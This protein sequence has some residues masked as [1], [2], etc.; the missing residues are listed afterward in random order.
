MVSAL[1]SKY[2]SMLMLTALCGACASNDTAS[3]DAKKASSTPEH[4]LDQT[5][6]A[7]PD[8]IPEK[9]DHFI[10][11]GRAGV[12]ESVVDAVVEDAWRQLDLDTGE[13]SDDEEAWDLSFSRYRVRING[14]ISGPGAVSVATLDDDF[15]D[16]KDIPDEA[17]FRGEDPDSTGENGDA[18]MEPDN[19]FYSSGDDWFNYNLMTHELTPRELTFVVKSTEARY[20]KLRFIAYYDRDNGTPGALTMRWI[21]LDS[22]P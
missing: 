2:I 16:V 22:A 21:E 11:R 1:R 18:D 17:A 10:H 15:E 19:A 4:K 6:T 7:L 5:E 8:A 12:I 9:Q 13:E 3:Q 14:G 20:Y